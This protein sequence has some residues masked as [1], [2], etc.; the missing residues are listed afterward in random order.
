MREISLNRAIRDLAAR[1][2]PARFAVEFGAGIDQLDLLVQKKTVTIAKLMEI[3]PA[4]T[5]DPTPGLYNSTMYLMV[6]VLLVAMA[7]NALMRPVH[8]RH[9]AR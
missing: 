9:H 7:A 4:G 3:A 1:I 5:V 8:S 6:V 2:D